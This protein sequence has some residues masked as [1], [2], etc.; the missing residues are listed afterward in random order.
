MGLDK[1][2]KFKWDT[3]MGIY[4]FLFSCPIIHLGTSDAEKTSFKKGLEAKKGC[5]KNG[6]SKIYR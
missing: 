3:F 2:I 6:F 1:K 5:L 4:H